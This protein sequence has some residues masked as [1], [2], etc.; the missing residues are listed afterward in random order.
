MKKL[1]EDLSSPEAMDAP[2]DEIERMLSAGGREISY[3]VVAAERRGFAVIAEQDP[4][5][6]GTNVPNIYAI[7][8]EPIRKEQ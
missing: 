3:R 8:K 1:E 6:A 5:Y 2:L 7:R 4:Y